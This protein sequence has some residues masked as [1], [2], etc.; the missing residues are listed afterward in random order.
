M[1]LSNKEQKAYFNPT[2]YYMALFGLFFLFDIVARDSGREYFMDNRNMS[3]KVVDVN[4]DGRKDLMIEETYFRFE[5]ISKLAGDSKKNISVFL[6]ESSGNY[7]LLE[8]AVKN[9]NF[10][11][12]SLADQY[13]HSIDSIA[14]NLK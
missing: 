1:T 7:V 2:K 13:V 11:S 10:K 5:K 8:D 12:K 14:D 4:N 9:M 3:T 6:Q